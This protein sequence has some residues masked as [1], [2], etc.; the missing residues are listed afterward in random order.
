MTSAHRL[1]FYP[2]RFWTH[3]MTPRA[4]CHSLQG[5]L[6][7]K[8]IALSR[9]IRTF[10]NI[11]C[12]RLSAESVTRKRFP[13][14]DFYIQLTIASTLAMSSGPNKSCDCFFRWSSSSNLANCSLTMAACSAFQMEPKRT[15]S[16]FVLSLPILKMFRTMANRQWQR[17]I[18]SRVRQ[19]LR[20]YQRTW[21]LRFS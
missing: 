10:R 12:H 20:K 5:C 19:T 4:M 16:L 8:K 2:K 11:R 17:V 7:L 14:S 18:P 1:S 15:N 13:D 9:P 6:H 3:T 21:R